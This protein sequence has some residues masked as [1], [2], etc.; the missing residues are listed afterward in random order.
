MC[1]KSWNQVVGRGMLWN[2]NQMV[3]IYLTSLIDIAE[4]MLT[5]Q[6]HF[7]NVGCV[8]CLFKKICPLKYVSLSY[9]QGD[10]ISKCIWQSNLIY[11]HSIKQ[12]WNYMENGYQWPW[13][14]VKNARERPGKLWITTLSVVCWKSSWH[15]WLDE[16][17]FWFEKKNNSIVN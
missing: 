2:I 5:P 6:I 10:L 3:A 1:A 8:F 4:S 12:T 16:F 17:M 7:C 9:N 14:V 15:Q 13:I 11:S